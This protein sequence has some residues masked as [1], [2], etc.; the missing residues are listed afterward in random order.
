VTIAYALREAAE[1]RLRI[2]DALGRHV[3]VLENGPREAGMHH[4][5]FDARGF[6]T[7]VYFY[8]LESGGV[9]LS[10]SMLYLK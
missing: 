1:V 6:P 2:F 9:I 7:G 3:A 5:R 8:H 10:G 4:V